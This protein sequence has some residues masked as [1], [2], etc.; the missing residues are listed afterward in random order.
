MAQSPKGCLYG[1]P[2]K[3]LVG[4]CAIYSETTVVV[5][6][7]EKKFCWVLPSRDKG[8]GMWL[9]EHTDGHHTSHTCNSRKS[10]C[11]RGQR[12]GEEGRWPNASTPHIEISASWSLLR[13]QRRPALT[14]EDSSASAWDQLLNHSWSSKNIHCGKFSDQSLRHESKE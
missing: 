13:S 3:G 8:I 9:V 11:T 12:A 4:V 1:P 7:G 14:V 10:R 5:A 2:S 6:S